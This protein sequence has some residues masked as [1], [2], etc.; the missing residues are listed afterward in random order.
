MCNMYKSDDRNKRRS[1]VVI[2][3]L[4]YNSSSRIDASL[5]E[6]EGVEAEEVEGLTKTIDALSLE[7]TVVWEKGGLSRS[8]KLQR[9]QLRDDPCE[10]V[11]CLLEELV[12]AVV[13]RAEVERR[14]RV[15]EGY[16]TRHL[17]A[18]LV[19]RTEVSQIGNTLGGALC[20]LE[21]SSSRMKAAWRI[22]LVSTA[23]QINTSF[24]RIL[25]RRQL[26]LNEELDLAGH[27]PRPIL[28]DAHGVFVRLI[29]ERERLIA[30]HEM[31][32]ESEDQEDTSIKQ[33]QDHSEPENSLVPA[34][35]AEIGDESSFI[36]ARLSAETIEELRNV[37]NRTLDLSVIYLKGATREVVDT[38]VQDIKNVVS[39]QTRL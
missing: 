16:L 22:I 19:K 21:S 10:M 23:Q 6:D 5:I 39:E 4:L 35:G 9:F 25:V 20:T 36:V 11:R 8:Y 12:E 38:A 15:V 24:R 2:D 14:E 31:R 27:P 3:S 17:P 34:A 26:Q 29:R 7:S 18:P 30:K 13:D 32:Q 1:F 28:T 37:T 33:I